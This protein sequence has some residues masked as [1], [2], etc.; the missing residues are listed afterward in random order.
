MNLKPNVFQSI[1]EF[2]KNAVFMEYNSSDFFGINIPDDAELI[3][4]DKV[5]SISTYPNLF[6]QNNN[7]DTRGKYYILSEK[8]YILDKLDID[9]KKSVLAH[10]LAHYNYYNN[11][12]SYQRGIIKEKYNYFC[13]DKEEF[14]ARIIQE[15][16]QFNYH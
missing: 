4:V 8:I 3:F 2:N 15:Y 1:I 5:N 6:Y 10:E 7:M 13:E 9:E 16:S 12:S 11:L 14:Y